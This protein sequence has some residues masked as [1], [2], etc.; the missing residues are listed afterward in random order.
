MARRYTKLTKDEWSCIIDRYASGVTTIPELS[1]RYSV[2]TSSIAQKVRAA[3]KVRTASFKPGAGIAAAAAA[4]A[5]I[6]LAPEPPI[7]AGKPTTAETEARIIATNA[8]ALSGALMI[9]RMLQ[10]SLA[11]MT[12]PTTPHDV[13]A[14]VR[15]LDQAAT[16][17]ERV[18]KIRRTVL[19]MDRENSQSDAIL[20]ELPIR[21][22]TTLETKS[23]RLEQALFDLNPLADPDHLDD[24]DQQLDQ[25]DD[26]AEP[27]H[28]EGFDLD[29][30]A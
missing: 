6:K 14:T 28:I 16:V 17:A 11:V 8:A 22:M 7:G 1:A 20:P 23:L 13:A 25:P 21:D 19:R 18:N 27:D 9:Q 24:P 15:M 29:L 2:S 4:V 12:L 5:G 3:G 30:A 10:A 26:E